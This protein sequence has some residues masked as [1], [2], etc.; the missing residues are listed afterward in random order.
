[1]PA[2]TKLAEKYGRDLPV[3]ADVDV[4]CNNVQVGEQPDL[5]R[6]V[7]VEPAA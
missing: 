5:V 2:L 7:Q 3:Q 6:I 1:M 4:F